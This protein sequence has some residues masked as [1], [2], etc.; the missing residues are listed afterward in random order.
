MSDIHKKIIDLRGLITKYDAAYYG[1]SESLISDQEYDALYKE[2]LELERTH[3][4]YDSPDSPTHRVGSDLTKVFPKVRHSTPMMSIDNTYST[5]EVMEWVGRME[6]TLEEAQINFVGE[7]K[8][9]GAACSLIYENGRLVRA[10]TRG[11]GVVGDEITA[12]IR[13]IRSVPLVV[14]Y[15]EPFEVRGEV[16]MT[17]ENFSA[18]NAA[19]VESGQKPMQNPRNTTAGTLKLQD[20]SEVAAR[21]LSFSAYFMFTGEHT[22]GHYDNLRLLQKLGFP[23]VVHSDVLTS[24]QE[25][26]DYCA[27]WEAERHTLAFPVDGVVVK[28]DSFDQQEILGSTAKSPRWVIAYKYQPEK[29]V[30]IVEN[31][32]SN[33][34]RTG[35]VTPIA[36]LSP[37]FLAGTTIKNATLHNYDEIERLGLRA[38]D[39]VEIEKGGEIIPKVM[40]VIL[41]K[42]P[43]SSMPF[44]PPVNCPSCGSSL[45]RLDKE[46]ALRCLSRACP[47]Q[48]FATLEHFVSRS[49]MDVRGMG[50]AIIKQ[51]LDSKLISDAADLYSLKWEELS[52][53]ER[54]ADKSA[55]NV[56]AAL[57]ESKSR[58]LDRLIHGLGIR[59]IGASSARDLADSVDDIA[60]LYTVTAEE[61]EKIDGFGSAMAQ[62]VRMFFD[63]EDNRKLIDRLREAGLNLK[64]SKSSIKK[65]GKVKGLTFVLTGTLEKYTREQASKI[66][67]DEGGKVTSSVSKKTDYVLAGAQA[68][69]KLDKAAALG[70]KVISEAE[71][72]Q[73]FLL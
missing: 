25:V 62:S 55:S 34:G 26:L 66:I 46:V 41:N 52:V 70:V 5:E 15:K 38:G 57:E 63:E 20:P 33:V 45:V 35:V 51:L 10:V 60:E 24:A 72:E 19:I 18:L 48:I 6:K 11:D 23:V 4:Q 36:R 64:G 44:V 8:V 40:L 50:P 31:I 69:S 53:L 30:T 1:R 59:M 43:E 32:D 14:D 27:K 21:N 12:N 42:R 47:A 7:I 61:L 37:V 67:M 13:T 29:T 22:F 71:F 16:Y 65:E 28:V 9:D 49:A 17:Y 58:P 54:M 2:L 39:S 73:L 56:I 3:P 68:G